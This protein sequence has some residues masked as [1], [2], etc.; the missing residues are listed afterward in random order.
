MAKVKVDKEKCIGCGA[1]I[2]MVPTVFEMGDDGKSQVKK[3]EVEGEELEEVRRAAE[4]C[5]TQA[6]SIE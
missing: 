5:P 3:E 4:L 2:A 6:I 1:C